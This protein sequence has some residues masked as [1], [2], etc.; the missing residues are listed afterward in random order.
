MKPISRH[1]ASG[2]SLLSSA[3]RFARRAAA[4]GCSGRPSVSPAPT[5]Q[6]IASGGTPAGSTGSITVPSEPGPVLPDAGQIDFA[7]G[8]PRSRRGEIGLPVRRSRNAGRR[9]GR[10]LGQE[11]WR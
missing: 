3:V 7:I 11:R 1:H 4:Q 8:R 2:L 9:M 10:P 6:N 5:F